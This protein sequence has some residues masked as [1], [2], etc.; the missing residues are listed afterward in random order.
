MS[1]FRIRG[2]DYA[3]DSLQHGL[4]KGSGRGRPVG[5]KNGQVMPGA[6][7]MKDYKIV[8][9]KAVVEPVTPGTINAQRTAQ[10]VAGTNNASANTRNTSARASGASSGRQ[11]AATTNRAATATTS[12]A[13]AASNPATTVAKGKSVVES[14]INKGSTAAASSAGNAQ[15]EPND[16]PWSARRVNEAG[17]LESRAGRQIVYDNP[18]LDED[19]KR[20]LA[21][22]YGDSDGRH[23]PKSVDE[24]REDWPEIHDSP[25]SARR[26]NEAGGIESREGRQIIYNNPDLNEDYKRHVAQYYGDSDGRSYPKSMDAQPSTS[27]KTSNTAAQETTTQAQNNQTSVS[28]QLSDAMNY[29]LL[30]AARSMA[31]SQSAGNQSPA[32][33]AQNNRAA[34]PQAVGNYANGVITGDVRQRGTAQVPEQNPTTQTPVQEQATAAQTPVQEQATAAQNPGL[35]DRIGGALNDAGQWLGNAAND[36]GQWLG[37][38]ANDVGRAVS[39]VVGSNPVNNQPVENT[40]REQTIPEQTIPEQI[41]PEQQA[42][43]RPLQEKS[44]ETPEQKSFWDNVGGWLTQAGK[45][46]GDTA[47]GAWN[48]VSGAAGDAAKWVGDRLGEAGDWATTAISDVGEWV[49]SRANEFGQWIG[50]TASNAADD[51]LGR[52]QVVDTDENGN[53]VYGNQRVGGFVD[54]AGRWVNNAAN[55]VGQFV[56]NT[57]ND[58]GRGVNDWWNGRDVEV[59]D[60][61][62]WRQG[63]E[64]GAR[65]NIT[66]A[67]GSAGQWI[68]N[69]A[70]DVGQ[71]VGNTANNVGRGVNDWWNGRDVE[72]NDNGHWRQGHEAGARENIGNALN[73][74][75]QWIGNAANDVGQF[76]G[77][78][79]N[80]V[81]RTASNA[82]DDLLGRYQ[83]VDTDENGNLVYGN[84]RV[85]GFVDR[86]G[87]WVNNAANDVSQWAG[88]TARAAD[89]YING[90]RP[91]SRE[92][93]SYWDLVSGQ[94]VDPTT[95]TLGDRIGQTVNNNVVVPAS[96]AANTAGQWVNENVVTP[97]SNAANAAGQWANENVVT[98]VSNA[99]NAA[100]QWLNEGIV[101]PV[102]SV[103]NNIGQSIGETAR[104]AGQAVNDWWN[105]TDVRGPITGITYSHN[106]GVRENIANA[107]DSAGRWVGNTANDVGQW[108]GNTVNDVGTQ[109]SI[110]SVV[111]SVRS[112]GVPQSTI[113]SLEEQYRSGE[114]TPSEYV[115]SLNRAAEYY[116]YMN[117][118]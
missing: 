74:A 29:A 34:M 95:Q 23:V 76:V 92:S 104:N 93:Q 8:G 77:N 5:S 107:L 17:G 97:V 20:Q 91:G 106:P 110:P 41:I 32:Q 78:T 35:L 88:N 37:N 54:R 22:R 114:L 55:D 80:N 102:T 63:H 66:N 56:G 42:T 90:P 79:A 51:L 46:I 112:S 94:F 4:G 113:E 25:Y 67:L 12:T 60:R 64:A 103:A 96:N 111:N 7:Y 57:A 2:I 9:Q 19:Y 39:G 45:D 14:M 43:E 40:I 58:I 109:I 38:A 15:K 10:K 50:N 53:P 59:N 62:H 21:K 13:R 99:A 16:S 69:A 18:G 117:G 89:T 73:S 3:D 82:A 108:V 11:T 71:W 100:G 28:K 52:Y 65:E 68:G 98:P 36:V 47:V 30:S 105:G 6:A 83:V 87:R 75:G 24:K 49:G 86:A 72:V 118:R 48:T 84:Q 26:I 1:Q 81:A 27:N 116:R 115:D 61:G 85:G 31:A 70:N 33:Q 101:A 44:P